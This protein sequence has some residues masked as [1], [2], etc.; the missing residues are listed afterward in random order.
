MSELLI[1]EKIRVV[2]MEFFGEK[3]YI[4][5][6]FVDILLKVGIKKFFL[7]VYF[8]NKDDLFLLIVYDLMNLFLIKLFVIY[9]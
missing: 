7:Y 4:E 2:V 8:K 6:L 3:G 1:V 9:E 5:I